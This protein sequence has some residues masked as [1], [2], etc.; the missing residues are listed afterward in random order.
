MPALFCMDE[1]ILEHVEV[2][3][4]TAGAMHGIITVTITTTITIATTAGPHG[5]WAAKG[6]CYAAC[7]A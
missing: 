4:T 6:C 3:R 2:H 5:G 7:G 1:H